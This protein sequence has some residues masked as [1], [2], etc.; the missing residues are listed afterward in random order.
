MENGFVYAMPNDT[1][2]RAGKCPREAGRFRQAPVPP[3]A[4]DDVMGRSTRRR[5]A[6]VAPLRIVSISGIRGLGC[7]RSMHVTVLNSDPRC[8]RVGEDIVVASPYD[9]LAEM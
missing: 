5:I 1:P 6:A 9:A 3:G 4:L 2:S 7:E 8:E